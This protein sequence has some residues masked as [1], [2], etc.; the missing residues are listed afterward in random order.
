MECSF[1]EM[2]FNNIKY[3]IGGIYRVPNTDINMFI[4]QFNSVIEPLN[5]SH[6]LIFLGDYNVDLL[7]NDIHKNNVEICL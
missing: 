3:L 4:E 5:S 1:I 6:K 7:K 2:Q